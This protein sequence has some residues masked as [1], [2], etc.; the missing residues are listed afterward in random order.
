MKFDQYQDIAGKTDQTYRRTEQKKFFIPLLGLIGEIGSLIAEYKK[1]L[2]DG[3]AHENY[4]KNVIEDLGDSL[5]YIATLARRYELSLSKIAYHALMIRTPEPLPLLEPDG[6]KKNI[7]AATQDDID[8]FQA[9]ASK[10]QRL[11]IEEE[12]N[13]FVALIETS[14]KSNELIDQCMRTDD[15][16]HQKTIMMVSQEYLMKRLKFAAILKSGES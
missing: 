16:H 1:Y 11:D 7:D 4:T 8:T 5:W 14:K 10:I 15:L 3:N 6:H 12:T 2:R 9:E 13:L